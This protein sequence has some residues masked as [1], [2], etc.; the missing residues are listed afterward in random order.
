MVSNER[1][2]IPLG[3]SSSNVSP[4]PPS[5]L[6]QPVGSARRTQNLSASSRLNLRVLFPRRPRRHPHSST[7]P[8]DFIPTIPT[9]E[10]ILHHPGDHE[11]QVRFRNRQRSFS[12]AKRNK[13]ATVFYNEFPPTMGT[14]HL[15]QHPKTAGT[16]VSPKIRDRSFLDGCNAPNRLFDEA[17]DLVHRGNLSSDLEFAVEPEVQHAMGIA[18]E[19]RFRKLEEENAYL[20]I[21]VNH[22]LKIISG[23]ETSSPSSVSGFEERNESQDGLLQDD[24][25]NRDN[26]LHR[27][28][29]ESR[30]LKASLLEVGRE[31]E[32]LCSTMADLR[33]K[34]VEQM[35][36]IQEEREE[37]EERLTTSRETCQTLE[38]A[39]YHLRDSLLS[40]IDKSDPQKLA[41]F[42]DDLQQQV[43]RI[44]SGV[45][46][47]KEQV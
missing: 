33:I 23:H 39:L 5:R 24:H 25:F 31:N 6:F 15:H 32:R 21:R 13:Q 46:I 2:S 7:L 35:R 4:T 11:P 12:R 43:Q 29:R 1:E 44:V 16:P 40:S 38:D 14:M 10:P 20:R 19:V 41:D 18:L 36:A 3:G 47:F 37:L 42:L 22:L 8:D 28:R 26:E 9:D 45:L 30:Q 27:L 34:G 17:E